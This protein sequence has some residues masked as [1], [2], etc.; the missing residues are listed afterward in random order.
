MVASR[1]ARAKPMIAAA[2]GRRSGSGPMPGEDSE[3][4]LR[5]IVPPH[6]AHR[7]GIRSRGS[8]VQLNPFRRIVSNRRT[9]ISPILRDPINKGGSRELDLFGIISPD[10]SI[11]TYLFFWGILRN[12]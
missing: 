9:T 11:V 6:A 8:K 2:W 4:L 7:P 1:A 5:F 12:P 10:P 3:V